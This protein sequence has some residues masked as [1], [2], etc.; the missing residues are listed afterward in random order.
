MLIKP[1]AIRRYGD[2]QVDWVSLLPSIRKGRYT[3]QST[4]SLSI[5]GDAPKN[6]LRIQEYTPGRPGRHPRRWIGYIAKVGSKCYPVESIT[7]HLLTRIGQVIGVRVADS[8]LRIVAGQ[9]RFLSRYFLRGRR[10]SLVHGLEIFRSY[11]DDD[12]M[13]DEIAAKKQEQ[14]FYTFETV[15]DALFEI[16]PEHVDNIMPEFVEM[17]AFDALVGNNDRHPL[18]WGVI[19]P[20]ADRGRIVFS[21]VFDTA[22][23]LF[24]NLDDSKLGPYTESVERLRAYV[25]RSRPQVGLNGHRS[26]NH[27]DLIE[28]IY[29]NYP[30]YRGNLEKFGSD[31]LVSACARVVDGEFHSLMSETR[32]RAICCCLELRH[33]LYCD[34][35]S[36]EQ[37]APK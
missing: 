7:E 9:V 22:R 3:V 33:Q 30:G 12:E 2:Y 8:H 20:V 35:I 32:R 34:A 1:A 16:F 26:P 37:G 25:D 36:T 6:F 19:T 13:V 24:W 4:D 5:H 11:L 14:E 15:Y 18:N 28:H 29:T 10:E 31:E 17:L 23:G 21:P 27:F